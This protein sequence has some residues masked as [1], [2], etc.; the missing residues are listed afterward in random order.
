[1]VNN[2]RTIENT[3]EMLK[4]MYQELRTKRFATLDIS[5][6]NNIDDLYALV[7]VRWCEALAKEGLYKE[8]VTV[9]N[10]E[11]TSPKGQI[12]IQES[13]TRQTMSR[14][15]LIC[16]YD[17]L[18]D[19]IYLNHILKGTLQYIIFDNNI[20]NLVKLEAKKMMQMFN[21]VDYT[22]ITKTHWKTIKYN[23]SNIRYKHL[24]D[25]CK[26]YVY[27]R[28]MVKKGLLDD[29]KRLYIMFKK[30]LYKWL[31][32]N[33][34]QDD[35]IIEYFEMPFT[36]DA[37]QVFERK[38]FKVQK[39]IAIRNEDTA[40]VICIR[41]QDELVLEDSTLTRK[42]SEELAKYL[43]EYSTEYKVKASGCLMY[44][45][46]NKNKLNLQPITV[47]VI[48]N[49]M[50]GETVIDI[51]D[52]N[53]FIA[54]KIRDCYKYFIARARNKKKPFSTKS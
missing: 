16:S 15:T 19:N 41:L 36:L 38:E 51:H 49:F 47:N 25:M 7:L 26:T 9:E 35:D 53:R 34:V 52:Y 13:I 39:M 37:E 14:G 29:N 48:D 33:C 12:N 28:D 5:Q 45:N 2:S 32:I 27:E 18:S 11:L 46:T 40:L 50:I 3:W 10:D 30:Q 1:M 23:N 21:G 6:V 24:L 42:H 54:N 22:D 43:R 8:Y 44:V 20:D 17:E 4:C 31:K